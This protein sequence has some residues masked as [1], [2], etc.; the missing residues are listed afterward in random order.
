MQIEARRFGELLN[1]WFRGLGRNWKPLLL[2]SLVVHVPLAILV[3][4]L[5]WATGA[6]QGFEAFL[7]PESLEALSPR[8]VL[9][10]LE[11]FIWTSIVWGILQLAAGAFVY[12]ASARTVA[13]DIAGQPAGWREVTRAS[14]RPA[15]VALLAALLVVVA[16]SILTAAVVAIGWAVLAGLD[17]NFLTIFIT[18]TCALTALVLIVWLGVSVFFASQVVALEGLGPIRALA[19]SFGL[20]RGRW[21]ATVGFV[22]LT[23]LVVSAASQVISIVLVP[24]YFVGFAY[25]EA[26]AIGLGAS[27]VLQGPLLAAMGAGYALW[28]VDLR[29]RTGPLSSEELV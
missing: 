19:R 15:A 5:F 24:V 6:S 14:W 25:S 23:G 1:E 26:L 12:V 17:V 7:D 22:L 9:D 27:A 10:L 2:T 20:V 13:G 16:A 21:W 29:T 11:P 28:Y 8:E 18:T 3:T 4:S